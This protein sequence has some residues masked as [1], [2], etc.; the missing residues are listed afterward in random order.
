MSAGGA[1]I[2]KHPK[3]ATARQP[4]LAG[5]LGR[6]IQLSRTPT[7]H[8]AEGA[9]QGLKYVYR[10]FDVDRMPADTT[11]GDVLKSAEICGFAGLN[12]TYPFKVAVIDHV[13]ELSDAAGAVGAVNTVVFHNGTRRGHNTDLWGFAESFRCSMDGA[14]RDAVALIGAGG[15]GAAVAHALLECGAARLLVFDQDRSKADA[16]AQKLVARHG[17]ERAVAMPEIS[18]ADLAGMDGIV[19]ATPVGTAAL[20]GIPIPVEMLHPRMWVADIVYFPLET[21]LLCQARKIG[22]R[23]LPGSGMAIFQAARAFEHFTGLKPDEKRMEA[24]FNA[25]D[26]PASP[27]GAS[28]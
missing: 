3:A 24:A 2:V 20:P 13:D 18:A 21:E 7:M 22:C 26:R 25:F 5:L 17:R 11:V 19:N 6:G 1:T 4:V 27:S 12:V 16:L 23:V 15:A 9:A 8:E 28:R 14:A 10:L